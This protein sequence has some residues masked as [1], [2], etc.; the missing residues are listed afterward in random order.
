MENVTKFSQMEGNEGSDMCIN[1]VLSHSK[2]G[3]VISREESVLRG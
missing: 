3:A 2:E 1:V